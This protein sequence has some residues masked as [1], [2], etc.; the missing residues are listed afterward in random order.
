MTKPTKKNIEKKR[1]AWSFR[2]V[3]LEGGRERERERGARLQQVKTT[4][5]NK[6]RQ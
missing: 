1:V 6:A 3:Q 4:N 2:L 5:N